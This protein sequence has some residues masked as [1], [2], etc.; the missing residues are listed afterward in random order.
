MSVLVVTDER[1]LDHRP[2]K[3]H[4]EQPARLEERISRQMT[5]STRSLQI[6]QRSKTYYVTVKTPT[7][8]QP[9]ILRT[10]PDR[11]LLLLVNCKVKS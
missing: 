4:L 8:K 10:N 11:A 9:F 2:G 3:R 6:L 7:K 5:P 1:F